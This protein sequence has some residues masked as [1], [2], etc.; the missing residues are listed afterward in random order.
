MIGR[1]LGVLVGAAALLGGCNLAKTLLNELQKEESSTSA[2][3]V[4]PAPAPD[5]PAA[6]ETNAQAGDPSPT[7]PSADAGEAEPANRKATNEAAVKRFDDEKKLDSLPLAERKGKIFA[8]AV[9]LLEEPP[10][11]KVVATLPKGTELE[12]LSE[13]QDHTLVLVENPKGQEES[14][15]LGWVS[16]AALAD[17]GS[18]PQTTAPAPSPPPPKTTPLPKPKPPTP[19]A[20]PKPKPTPPPKADPPEESSDSKKKKKKKKKGE[21]LQ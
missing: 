12:R 20:P 2:E 15:L 10:K 4:D 21:T 1:Q 19:I 16:S 5:A 6:G 18:E 17:A 14:L 13:H 9:E 7:E 11:G 3:E 8:E